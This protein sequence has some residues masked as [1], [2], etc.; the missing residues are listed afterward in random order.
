MLKL[1]TKRT[2][3]VGFAFLSICSFWQLY[4]S[5]IPLILKNTF[6]IGDTLSGGIMAIDN[7][8]ALFMLPLFGSLSD[9][10]STRIGKRMPYIICGTAAA[11]VFM[12]LMAI[13]DTK[14]NL[15]MFMV[16]LGLTLISMATYRSPA[17]ALMSDVTH[18]QL[19][20]KANAIIN[21]MG[22][23]G[24]I[25]SLVLIKVGMPSSGRVNYS[26]LFGAVSAIMVTAVAILF[27]TIRENALVAERE[28]LE[29]R[30]P[31]V[32]DMEQESGNAALSK[33]IKK[34][35]IGILLCIF[36]F[37]MAYNAVTTAF[38]KY[39]QG[40]LGLAG[41]NFAGVMMIATVV[42]TLSYV[43]IGMVTSKIGRKKA[44]LGGILIMAGSFAAAACIKTYS[45][46]FKIILSLM[47]MGYASII[48]N[49]LPMVV[50]M[51]KGSDIGKYTGIYYTFSMSA[52]II[53]PVLSGAL[54]EYV[55]YFTLFPYAVVCL[56]VSFIAMLG[57]KH[58]DS[59]VVEKK[60]LEAFDVD[61]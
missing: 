32:D 37:F 55:G 24:A 57:V 8:L 19:R 38:S 22:T 17:V 13:A 4:D 34:S 59:A 46:V 21:L 14:V 9:K 7:V 5:V 23:V 28:E 2:I 12:N 18:K 3:L 30:F 39:A 11:V 48:V 45:D 43:P 53:T 40:Y 29:R 50:E 31:T 10:T 20:S 35:L 6:H 44:V 16:F 1:N 26:I 25:L 54:L 41:G 51:S 15:I 49:T 60:G 52:Q 61:D 56:V 27:I 33:E 58:G 42:A 47:G 36:F